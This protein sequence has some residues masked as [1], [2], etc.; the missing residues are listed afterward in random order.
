MTS[1]LLE[2][3]FDENL[4][5]CV[6]NLQWHFIFQEIK[7]DLNDFLRNFGELPREVKKLFWLSLI[8]ER[9]FNIVKDLEVENISYVVD[10]NA[11]RLIQLNDSEIY[12]RKR[13]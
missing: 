9:C 13:F 1:H 4:N 5:P 8:S 2:Y 11:Y 7:C 3:D 6:T 12:F 10:E